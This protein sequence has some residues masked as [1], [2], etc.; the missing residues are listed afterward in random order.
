MTSTSL[1]QLTI[2]GYQLIN[3]HNI[4][5]MLIRLVIDLV[6]TLIIIRLV[7]YPIYKERDY[8]FTTILVN[9]SVFF[10]CFL[11]ASIK[12]Q[13]G[14][15]FGLFAV[16]SIIRYRTQQI[17]IREMTYIF[18]VIII[19]VINAISNEKISYAELLLANIVIL[20]AIYILE[21]NFLHGREIV[22]LIIYEKI[23][24]VKPENYEKLI[25]DLKERTGLAIQKAEIDSINF[26][27]DTAK[28]KITY[29]YPELA[30]IDKDK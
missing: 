25:K 20:I 30:E 22:K 26:L 2:Y 24:L 6:F 23:E 4:N 14:F 10:I 7:F 21:H 16:F 5:H 15:A 18:V 19:A 11:L 1:E 12:L 3:I 28:L 27:N 13:I 17:P 29:K 8:V 9:L